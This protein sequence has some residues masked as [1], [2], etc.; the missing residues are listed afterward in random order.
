MGFQRINS[1]LLL[2]LWFFH[3]LLVA[4][5]QNEKFSIIEYS[6]AAEN[7]LELF[8]Q[9]SA[10]HGKVY[11][12]PS[13]RAM[14][15]ENFL[16]NLAYVLER[17]AKREL[18]SIGHTVGLNAFAD[19][20]NEEF[21]VKYLSKMKLL[22]KTKMVE[23]E[24]KTEECDAPYSLD[25]RKKGAVTGV[26]DQGQCGSCWAFSSTGA[27]EGIN[28]ITIGDLISLSEQELVDCDTTNEGCD[29]GNMDYAFEWV[30]NNGGIATEYDYPYTGQD[31]RCNIEKEN[32][33]AVTIDG[34]QDVAPDE[35][36]LLCA[37][38][39]QPVSV[40]IDGS[41]IDFQLYT[42]G[43]YD[44]DCSSDP[45]DID[46]AVLIVGYGSEKNIDYW[47]VKNSWGTSWGMKG[48]IYIRRNTGLPYGV[49]A[50]NVMASYPIKE[51][52]SPSPFPPPA[53]PPPPPPPPPPPGPLPVQCGELSYCSGGETC[54]CIYQWMNFCLV[55]GCCPYENAI[56]CARSV[57]CCPQDYPICD[58][59][60]GL[61]LQK[62]R[63]F[64]G[65][66]A[67]KIK[68]AKHKLPWE[69]I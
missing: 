52:T 33:K 45:A 35:N 48:Y 68:L 5:I 26:K 11:Q 32:I 61:C 2:V 1:S 16:K 41:S 6:H 66:K 14:R 59:K 25:W 15:F 42:G 69:A 23:I 49:C 43:I 55:Y 9:W 51:S 8:E 17:N 24:G 31:G 20:S 30:I 57:Y 22:G 54:C 27:M 21:R 4:S 62:N 12:H 13:E 40:G 3:T 10:K 63:D 28:A 7:G 18:T 19:L 36:A 46:H 58:I 37:V 60:E 56:C 38:A 50:I 47:I 34:Y 44:G 67:N 64:T 39:K 65:I 53:I 29:G